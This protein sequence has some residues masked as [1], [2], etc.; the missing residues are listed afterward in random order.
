MLRKLAFACLCAAALSASALAEET[1]AFGTADEARAMLEKAVAA[2]KAD[3]TKA[4]DMFNSEEGGFRDRDLYVFCANVSD[5]IETAHP[6]HKGQK[7]TDIKDANGFAFGEE[8]MKT[9]K[10]GEIS[11]V[12]YMWPRPN[13]DTPAEKVTFVTKVEDQVCAVGYYK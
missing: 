7:L 1:A 6:T 10:E 4:L 13:S 11:E 3:K 2:V 8:I 9:A 5:G 12:T